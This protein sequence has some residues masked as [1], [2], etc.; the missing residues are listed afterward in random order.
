MRIEDAAFQP[1]PCARSVNRHGRLPSPL[2]LVFAAGCLCGGVGAAPFPQASFKMAVLANPR[3]MFER[4]PDWG[5][6]AAWAHQN[7]FEALSLHAHAFLLCLAWT[8]RN[9]D[10]RPSLSGLISRPSELLSL[11]ETE[12]AG[13]KRNR[14]PKTSPG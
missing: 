11:Q 5:K 7:C 10:T 6:R 13:A 14:G 8:S 1:G 4:L 9:A 2:R 3:A 12:A